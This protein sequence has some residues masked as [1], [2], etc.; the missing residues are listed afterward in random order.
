MSRLVPAGEPLGQKNQ[1]CLVNEKTE[2]PPGYKLKKGRRLDAK[3]CLP[4]EL[5]SQFKIAYECLDFIMDAAL[6]IH[7]I[8]PVIEVVDTYSAVPILRSQNRDSPLRTSP[9]IKPS[10][11]SGLIRHLPSAIKLQIYA[12]SSEYPVDI[13]VACG[14]LLNDILG[15]A[16]S[17]DKKLL[18]RGSRSVIINK[19]VSLKIQASSVSLE[20]RKKAEL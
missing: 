16:A 12:L 11:F 20:Q 7:L 6:G 13:L 2:I 18:H 8:E 5:P 3:H 1:I 9:S 19:A 10:F 15:S 17:G 14:D 4:F